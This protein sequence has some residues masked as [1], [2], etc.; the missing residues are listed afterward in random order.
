MTTLALFI[1]RLLSIYSFVI[2][3][4]I[5]A[6]WI[7]PFPQPGSFTYYLARIVDP[8]LNTFRSRRFRAGMLDFS[9]IIGIGVLSVVQSVFEIYGTYGMMSLS[10]IVQ[11]FISAFWSY[12]VS[13]FFTFGFIL[14][15]IKTIAS[16]MR[17]SAFSMG[18]SR[19]GSFI[20]PVISWVRRTFFKTRFVRESTLNLISLLIFVVLYFAL[21][22]I[23]TVA[24]HLA[25]RIP[26]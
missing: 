1:A 17:N 2:W 23:F 20:D 7:N 16:F 26:F 25:V 10:L 24:I 13:I 21:K 5:L 8:Y 9:P 22:Y 12:G 15:V 19:M 3:I 18:M 14:L 6:S 4:R 11:L